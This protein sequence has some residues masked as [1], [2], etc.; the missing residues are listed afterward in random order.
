MCAGMRALEQHREYKAQKLFSKEV[1]FSFRV[2]H[3]KEAAS[4]EV[5]SFLSVF[6]L[7]GSCCWK[8]FI[9][10]LGGHLLFIETERKSRRRM[11]SKT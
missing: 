10:F 1:K 5:G 11:G 2:Y 4:G 8:R 3:L 7:K 9:D 6:G